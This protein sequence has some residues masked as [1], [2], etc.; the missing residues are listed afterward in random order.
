MHKLYIFWSTLNH[1]LNLLFVDILQPNDPIIGLPT[2]GTIELQDVPY[3]TTTKHYIEQ[4]ADLKKKIVV[5]PYKSNIQKA[6]Y[7]A[8]FKY[9]DVYPCEITYKRSMSSDD[10]SY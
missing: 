7:Q 3:R 2:S 4:D 1:K 5:L 6:P 8:A 10:Q 9:N